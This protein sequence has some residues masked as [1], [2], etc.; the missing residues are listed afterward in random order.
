MAGLN[1]TDARREELIKTK[2]KT[3]KELSDVLTVTVW[4]DLEENTYSLGE[5]LIIKNIRNALRKIPFLSA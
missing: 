2:V 1:F 5:K 4:K 3:Q